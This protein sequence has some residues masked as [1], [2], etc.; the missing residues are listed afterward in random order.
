A[1]LEASNGLEPLLYVKRERPDAVVLDLMMP[2]LGGVE[3]LK[4]IRSYNPGI[5]VLVVTGNIDPELQRQA[6]A[7]GAA[8][9]FTKP[10]PAATLV[11]ALAGAPLPAPSPAP[12]PAP[13]AP[14][15]G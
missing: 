5:R 4:R 8:A 12:A 1:V 14:A 6:T 11:A 9:V 3:A 7:A 10:V 2:R 13:P 15:P